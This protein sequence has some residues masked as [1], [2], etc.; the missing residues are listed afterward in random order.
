MTADVITYT[1]PELQTFRTG[2]FDAA[3]EFRPELTRL[4]TTLSGSTRYLRP[5]R[6][7]YL[8]RHSID[9]SITSKIERDKVNPLSLCVK[10]VE[11][12][13]P[14]IKGLLEGRSG[15]PDFR[16]IESALNWIDQQCREGEL[17]TLAGARQLYQDYTV[18]LR[19]RTLLSNVGDSAKSIG[20]A[21]AQT[22]QLGMAYLCGI[23]CKLDIDVIQSWAIRISYKGSHVKEL[24][25]PVTTAEEHETAYALHKRFFYA[26]SQAVLDNSTPPVVVELK[27]LGFEDLIYYHRDANNC[28]GEW[29][30]ST[31]ER[32]RVDWH[33]FFYQRDGVFQG[34]FR[35]FKT[36]LA[37]HGIAPTNEKSFRK[38]QKHNL[39]YSSSTLRELANHATRHFG[40]LLLSEAG[41]NAA[42]L[43]TVDCRNDKLDKALGLAFTRAIKG[44]AGYE[45]QD[46]LVDIRFA[47]TI[48]KQY[49]KLREW[50][51]LQL[52]SPPDV[53]I[54][55]LTKRSRS[56]Y[57]LLSQ[58]SL[59][60]LPLWPE[61]G[62]SLTTRSARKHKTVNI[63]E[64]SSGNVLLAANMQFAT[65]Q[66]IERHY[67]FKNR[68]EAAKVM[69][70]Y[71]DAQAKA[72]ELRSMGIKPVRIIEG[73][74]KTHS[75]ICDADTNDPKLI[76]DF[77]ELGIEPRCGAPV[78]CIFCVH[79]GLH[80][81]IED[82][83]RLLTIKL[84]IEVQSRISSINID[85]HFRKFSPYINRL[86]QILNELL[87]ASGRVSELANNALFRF[88]RG[89]RDAYWNAKISGLLEMEEI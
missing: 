70:E 40:Y 86:Q 77:E 3:P 11:L 87:N 27:D 16:V 37:A 45:V 67:A 17:Y 61:R 76:P 32:R 88:E 55:L 79:F 56:P 60:Q 58:E 59:R 35:D 89:E 52:Q 15:V 43:A 81:D 33:P 24:P 20:F 80:A 85:D 47:Q 39:Q 64:S 42:H 71:F 26:F 28:G 22:L 25:A 9:S 2:S 73:G 66:T 31:S 44:R 36:H 75:G 23:A 19:H 50:M 1:T 10:R 5:Y 34:K 13:K 78:T 82:I 51:S 63:L 62:P 68:E 84:W 8:D 4:V 74:E 29:S 54:F 30:K 18:H 57:R 72:A 49:R 14:I 53:G 21:T 6:V 69:N 38:M 65:P 12:I 41:N 7:C 83:L 48:W 46:Q